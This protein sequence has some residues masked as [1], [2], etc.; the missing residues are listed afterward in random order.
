MGFQTYCHIDIGGKQHIQALRIIMIDEQV[1][2][3]ITL[4]F[5]AKV[6]SILLYDVPID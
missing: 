5:F 2:K 3:K 6:I 1:Y 4:T